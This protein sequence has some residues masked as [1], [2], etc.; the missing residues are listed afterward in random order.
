MQAF[1]DEMERFLREAKK[2]GVQFITGT[3]SV[4]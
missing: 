3:E 1:S 2:Y 4:F